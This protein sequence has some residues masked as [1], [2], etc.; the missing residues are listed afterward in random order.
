[1]WH[2]DEKNLH[3]SIGH[4]CAHPDSILFPSTNFSWN[5]RLDVAGSDLH[6]VEKRKAI[7]VYQNTQ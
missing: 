4:F 6:D 1:M 3:G 5:R 7:L 2:M